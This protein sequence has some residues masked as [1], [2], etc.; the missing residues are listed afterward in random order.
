LD[1]ANALLPGRVNLYQLTPELSAALNRAAETARSSPANDAGF[2]DQAA[3]FLD[4]AT[5]GHYRVRDGFVDAVEFT[6]IYPA[7]TIEGTTT[8]NGETLPAFGV[9]GIWPLIRRSEGR[10]LTGMV[11]YISPNPGYGYIPMLPSAPAASSTTPFTTPA[12]AASSVRRRSCPA[13]GA[14]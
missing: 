11:D 14:R 4:R 9:T 6:A 3:A 7:G 1:A 2:R 5:N 10:G 12:S 13:P 8:Y